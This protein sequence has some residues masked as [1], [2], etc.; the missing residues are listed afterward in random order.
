MATLWEKNSVTPS[1]SAAEDLNSSM[2]IDSRLHKEYILGSIAHVEMLAKRGIILG[3]DAETISNEMFGILRD[4]K[5]G[6][7]KLDNHAEDIHSFVEK[8]LTRRV[9]DAGKKLH[10]ARSRNDQCALDLRMALRT[11]LDE[12]VDLIKCLITACTEQAEAH[13]DTLMPGYTHM[14]RAQPISFAHHMMAYS[15]ML[16]RDIER[17]HDCRKRMNYCPLGSGALAGTTYPIDRVISAQ[18]LGFDG[19]CMN[20]MDAVADRDHVIEF[21][22]ALSV[23]MMHLSRMSEDIM[24]WTSAEWQFARLDDAFTTSSSMMPQ[25][26]NPVIAELIR[27]KTGRVYGSLTALLTMM[28]GLP[29]SYNKDMQEDKE[30]VFEAVDVVK[31]CLRAFAP[32]I[33]TMQV[34]KEQMRQAAEQGFINATD[35]ADY[36]VRAGVPFRT[37]FEVTSEIIRYCEANGKRLE[38]LTLEEYQQFAPQF[39]E[40]VYDAISLD[41][42]IKRRTSQGGTA[43]E[44]VKEQIVYVQ[45]QLQK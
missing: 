11:E 28:K 23:V 39:K 8:E 12:T 4:I 24:L 40:D 3:A 44:C 32:M 33:A 35:C 38:T 17:L 14:Q 10:T 36:L 27:G 7:L 30:S 2:R 18:K 16:V 1:N 13:L 45:E 31:A 15:M 34:N 43:P 26:R 9:G 21:A 22:S 19:V 5:S 29:L 42:C 20:S 37:A 25:K 41:A 6:Y